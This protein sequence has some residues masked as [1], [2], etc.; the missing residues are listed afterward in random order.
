MQADHIHTIEE[1]GF[2]ILRRVFHGLKGNLQ[3]FFI[4]PVDFLKLATIISTHSRGVLTAPI[5]DL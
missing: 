1:A 4:L 3:I 2:W 5:F